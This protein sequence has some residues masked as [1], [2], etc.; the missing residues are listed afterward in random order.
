M[1]PVA[2]L[3]GLAV[4]LVFVVPVGGRAVSWLTARSIGCPPRRGRDTAPKSIGRVSAQP[5][6]DALVEGTPRIPHR[7]KT[8]KNA[9]AVLYAR[10]YERVV[11]AIGRRDTKLSPET[12][13]ATLDSATADGVGPAGSPAKL[14]GTDIAGAAY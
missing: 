10:R 13:L 11:V 12:L 14:L 1:R 4:E 5:I 7:L 9:I 3:A 6:L 8:R 2:E